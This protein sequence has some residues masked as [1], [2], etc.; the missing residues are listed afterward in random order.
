[1]VTAL[2]LYSGSLAS[3][4]AARLVARSPFVDRTALLHFRSPFFAEDERL[5][6]QVKEEWP[7]AIFRT[8]SLK[9]DYRRLANIPPGRPFSLKRSCLSCRTL[10]LVRAIRYM[11]RI[12]ADFIV[13]G[14]LVGRHGLGPEELERI[15]ED[16]GVGGLVVRPLSARLLPPSL[17]EREGW[18][19]HGA[20][21][22]L[23]DEDEGRLDALARR[24]RL[25]VDDSMNVHTRCKL[26]HPGFG[27]RLENLFEED[28]FTLN[29]LKLLEFSLY[30]KYPPD[31][32]IVLAIDEEEKR[33]LQT[34]FLPQDLRVYLPS[35]R[36][37]LA[38]VRTDWGSKP[39]QEVEEIITLV[40][41]IAVT[42]SPAAAGRSVPV[43]Y[44]FEKDD[45]TS[46]LNILPFGSVDDIARVCFACNVAAPAATSEVPLS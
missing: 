7:G 16:L 35:P 21:C 12:K 43:K 19:D 39:P 26:T 1:V 15:T 2:C 37:P 3:R 29:A 18:L 4:V 41:R 44:R 42:H 36:S 8:Q 10:M 30:Y 25:P 24:L 38:L 33:A 28:R 31:V 46:Q 20:L 17:P 32:K 13:T 40:A 22:D 45:E 5:R 9:K 6:E 23:R 34:F 27:R 11:E 14:D